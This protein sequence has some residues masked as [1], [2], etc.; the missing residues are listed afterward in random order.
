M[1]RLIEKRRCKRHTELCRRLERRRIDRGRALGGRVHVAGAPFWIFHPTPTIVHAGIT[2]VLPEWTMAVLVHGGKKSNPHVLTYSERRY[3]G[4][5]VSV[6]DATRLG[7]RD[8]A[9]DTPKEERPLGWPVAGRYAPE[10]TAEG[11]W[12][13]AWE[14][15]AAPHG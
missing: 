10:R 11:G 7:L 12:C 13:I 9:V 8:F 14:D 15:E 4:F 5:A 2:V 3:T 1:K 6:W